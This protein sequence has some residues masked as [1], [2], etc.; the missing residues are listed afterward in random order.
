MSRS[1]LRSFVT[2]RLVTAW[3]HCP[4]VEEN[5]STETP[6]DGGA[7]LTV[8]YPFAREEQTSIGAPGANR[9]S[10]FGAVRFGLFAPTGAGAS[11]YVDW[12]DALGAS[13]RNLQAGDIQFD[14][15]DPPVIGPRT[16][17]GNYVEISIAVAYRIDIY[18]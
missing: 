6:A 10:T 9:M 7:F 15:A 8:E 4:V 2:A 12:L 1:A 13:F 5:T 3:T 17:D 16:D 14:S 11:P 18:A